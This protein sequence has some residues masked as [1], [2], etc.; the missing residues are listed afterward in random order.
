MVDGKRLKGFLLLAF[1]ETKES[2]KQRVVVRSSAGHGIGEPQLERRNT[3]R[4]P[5]KLEMRCKGFGGT[6]DGR[7]R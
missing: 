1:L 3:S 5:R 6:R 7:Y 2:E 4:A